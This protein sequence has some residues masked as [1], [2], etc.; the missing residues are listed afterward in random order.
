M[1]THR[2]KPLALVL[3]RA[4]VTGSIVASAPAVLA[5]AER[6]VVTGS[7]ILRTQVEG[8]LPVLTLDRQ[9]I[10]QSGATTATDL[11]Q[12]LPQV[13]NFVASST[14]VNGSGQGNTTAALHALPSKYTLVLI[15]GVRPPPAALNNS[16]GGGFA[17]AIQAIPLDAVERVEILLDGATAVYGS[18]A[19]AGVVNFILK[20]NTT[21][22]N[23]YAQY[24]WPTKGDAQGVNVGVSKGWG[25]LAKDGW[26][27]MGT[28]SYAHQS[29]LQATDRKVSKQGAYFP[30]T[31]NGVNY[32]FNNATENTEPGNLIFQAY[33]LPIRRLRR[34]RTRS[35][36]TT[37]KMATARFRPS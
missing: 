18:D 31:H 9:Y 3:A 15:D 12:Q 30:F 35:T 10:E 2:R 25:D 34:R 14:G 13:Q 1:S 6:I 32:I 28:F 19:V 17:A 29:K 27:V 37:G 4:V 8:A 16:F 21:E 36:R 5:Q 24:T 23:A 22:G 20:K 33:R 7:S 11:I 26:N